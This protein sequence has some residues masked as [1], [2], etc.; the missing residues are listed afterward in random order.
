MK[1]ISLLLVIFAIFL[2]FSCD[3]LNGVLT[4]TQDT[5]IENNLSESKGINELENNTFEDA[6][7]NV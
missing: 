7:S 3:G 1:K 4:N 6:D 5:T 2:F